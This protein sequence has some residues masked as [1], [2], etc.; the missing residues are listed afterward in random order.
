MNMNMFG[1]PHTG[2]DIC[3]FYAEPSLSWQ[4]QQEVCG[5]WIQLSTFYPFARQHRNA[6]GWKPNEP[7]NF[8][9]EYREMAIE[10]IK[11]RYKYLMLMQTCL[12]TAEET[13]NTCF[14]PLFFHYPDASQDDIEHTFIAANSI[15]VSPVL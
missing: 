15:K 7:Y 4:E 14:D 3:G 6:S 1:V 11:E 12:K 13:G 2:P 8:D 9:P 5:R 10:S